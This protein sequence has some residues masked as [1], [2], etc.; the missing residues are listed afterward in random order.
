[1]GPSDYASARAAAKTCVVDGRPYL[2]TVSVDVAAPPS[3]A[4]AAVLCL[5]AAGPTPDAAA[6]ED[7]GA[8]AAAGLTVTA[9][10]G[11]ITNALFRVAGLAGAAGCAHAGDSVLVR[12]SRLSGRT[13][14]VPVK[15]QAAAPTVTP[16]HRRCPLPPRSSASPRSSAPR[17]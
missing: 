17:A 9:V 6:R 4:R 11:G 15:Q 2:P 10:T 14:D 12:V 7:V 5:R 8:D 16:L 3:V 1:M 13:A